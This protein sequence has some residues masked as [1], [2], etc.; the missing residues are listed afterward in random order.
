MNRKKLVALIMVLALA[1]TTLVGGTLAYFTDEDDATNVFTMG[2]VE[3]DLLEDFEPYSN[4]QPGLDI[5]K[6]VSVRNTGSNDAYVRVHIAM[7]ANM[8]DGD[9]RF[10]ASRNFLHFNFDMDSVVY[11]QWSWLPTYSAGTGY[12]SDWNFYTQNIDG[13]DYNVYVVTYRSALASGEETG[14]DAITKVYLDKTVDVVETEKTK[15]ENGEDV[16]VSYTYE[17]TKGNRIKLSV[18]EAQN[19]QIKV[20]AEGAQTA[21]FENAYDALNTAFGVPGTYNPWA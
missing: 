9:P 2:N 13:K 1:F 21:T 5:N 20:I 16:V 4:L 7:P 18:E 10:D 14:T 15:D 3:I 6:D 12:G 8:D 17:D 19:I 11:G